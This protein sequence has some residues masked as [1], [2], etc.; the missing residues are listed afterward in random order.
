LCFQKQ[1]TWKGK[2]A[3]ST[4]AQQLCEEIDNLPIPMHEASSN[5]PMALPAFLVERSQMTLSMNLERYL[6]ACN[7]F[8]ILAAY[9]PPSPILA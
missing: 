9:C 7:R 8:M 2:L 3:R 1:N 4:P 6:T 5:D